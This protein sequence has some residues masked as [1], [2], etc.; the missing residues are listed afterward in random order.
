MKLL[1]NFKD[2]DKVK[3]KCINCG[4]NFKRRLVELGLFDGSKIKIIKNDQHSPLILEIFDSKVALG[5]GEA[6]KIY[7]EKI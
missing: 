2:N 5:R 7:A 4:I 3:I 6:E 1:S